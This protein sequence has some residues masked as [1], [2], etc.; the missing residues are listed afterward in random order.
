MLKPLLDAPM[1]LTIHTLVHV[2]YPAY[3]PQP[4]YRRGLDEIVHFEKYDRSKFRSGEQITE[5]IRDLRKATQSAYKQEW[6]QR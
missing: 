3:E 5:F 1:V 2:G 6:P 4:P